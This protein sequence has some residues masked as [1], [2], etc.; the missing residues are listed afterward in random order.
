MVAG[1]AA[2]AWGAAA[3]AS[4]RPVFVSRRRSG[5]GVGRRT[6]T[7]VNCSL[8][9]NPSPRGPSPNL[10]ANLCTRCCVV[11]G[12]CSSRPRGHLHIAPLWFASC[13][14]KNVFWSNR[15]P[16]IRIREGR[17]MGED[18][19]RPGVPRPPRAPGWLVLCSCTG[20]GVIVARRVEHMLCRR[21][22]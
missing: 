10:H 12:T 15:F 18:G 5:R 14:L 13:K 21:L 3:A 20:Q 4:W 19:I 6:P 17:R 11:S 22:K 16:A 8:S 1:V 7:T 2:A 9:L